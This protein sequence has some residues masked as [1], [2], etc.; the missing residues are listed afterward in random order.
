MNT[1]TGMTATGASTARMLARVAERRAG[2][3]SGSAVWMRPYLSH[4]RMAM[5]GRAKL[6]QVGDAADAAKEGDEHDGEG[7][8]EGAGG[9]FEEAGVVAGGTDA[10]GF[11]GGGEG[12]CGVDGGAAE[13]AG[14]GEVVDG[15]A[16]VGAGEDLD[17]FA[18]RVVGHVR[19]LRFW[20][21]RRLTCVFLHAGRDQ[22]RAD[23]G[24]ISEIGG[25]GTVCV[26]P[27]RLGNALFSAQC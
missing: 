19:G 7:G 17:A 16:A 26:R 2:A 11:S 14:L 21:G 23:G 15:L 8:E 4:Q 27:S 25:P 6:R 13:G 10:A 3:K 18:I 22:G 20:S 12:G 1:R 9:D 5:T 24:D